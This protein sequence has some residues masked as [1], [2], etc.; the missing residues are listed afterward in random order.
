VDPKRHPA[1]VALAIS[2]AWRLYRWRAYLV[3]FAVG[4]IAAG[5]VAPIVT[6]SVEL[7]LAFGRSVGEGPV[8][9]A[10]WPYAIWSVV[11]VMTTALF[12]AALNA[13]WQ[14]DE[15]KR[16]AQA[17]LWLAMQAETRWRR[18]T[19]ED[20]VPRHAAG[21]REFLARTAPTR[22]NAEERLGLWLALLDLPQ[23][24]AAVAE[25]PDNTPVARHRR[26]SASWLIEFAEGKDQSAALRVLDDFAGAIDDDAGRSEAVAD[27]ALAGA[28]WALA[29]G[30]DWRPPLAAV[31][32]QL[33]SAPDEIYAQWL[34]R[35]AFRRLL[36][37]CAIGTMVFWLAWW[38]LAPYFQIARW[39]T[40]S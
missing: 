37:S 23:A 20:T 30:Q 34:W 6:S 2:R 15:L 5:V 8:G 7:A 26:A 38:L 11:F 16:A 28:R 32:P 27:N 10:W 24:R 13:R 25:M 19:G 18:T 4:M 36:V 3:S 33:G 14:P 21:M 29:E 39:Q 40:A 35:P 31:R 12:G 22:E 17:Y 1:A 9:P